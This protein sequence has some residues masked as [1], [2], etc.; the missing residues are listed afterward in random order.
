[1]FVRCRCLADQVEESSEKE[2]SQTNSSSSFAQ[3]RANLA[4]KSDSSVKVSSID[5]FN[6]RQKAEKA[7]AKNSKGEAAARMHDFRESAVS[8]QANTTARRESSIRKAANRAAAAVNDGT[9]TRASVALFRDTT[10]SSSSSGEASSPKVVVRSLAEFYQVQ[11][12]LRQTEMVARKQASDMKYLGYVSL[13][14]NSKMETKFEEKSEAKESREAAVDSE[15]ADVIIQLL[16]KNHAQGELETCDDHGVA[17]V[18]QESEVKGGGEKQAHDTVP[19]AITSQVGVAEIEN[20]VVLVDYKDSDYRGFIFVVHENHGLMLLHCTR[21]RKKGP[22]HQL[23]GGHIDEPEFLAA[24]RMSP[25]AH[26]QLIIAAQMGAAREL[27]E[28]TGMDVRDKL[29]RLEPAALR[30]GVSTNKNGKFILP[31]ELKKRLYFFLPVTDGDFISLGLT[32]PMTDEGSH[33][34]L[35]LSIEHSG[36]VFEKDPEISANLLKSHSGGH[37]SK[38]LLMAMEREEEDKIDIDTSFLS[39]DTSIDDEEEQEEVS[40]GDM[41]EVDEETPLIQLA[42]AQ[43]L[44]PEDML[45]ADAVMPIIQLSDEI[46]SVS[47][48]EETQ[49]LITPDQDAAFN[50]KELPIDLLPPPER[51]NFLTCCFCVLHQK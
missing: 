37:G 36:F 5:D 28:E 26:A 33:L 39:V 19:K 1:M 45:Q 40:P 35:K 27:F 51:K 42:E 22:H 12:E 29:F 25:D 32:A 47:K 34:R 24:A 4:R 11:R 49:A 13:L 14:T 41:F 38:A 7:G 8:P 10:E 2:D 31:S 44:I 50:L 18:E 3:L 9:A 16:G 15:E 30:N 43:V 23:P 6:Q 21:K 20:P 46:W 17:A 48:G